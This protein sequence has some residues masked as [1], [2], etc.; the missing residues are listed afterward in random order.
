MKS[1][2]EKAYLRRASQGLLKEPLHSRALRLW[3]GPGEAREGVLQNW[4]IDGYGPFLWI[5]E[6]EAALAS[7]T[8]LAW[9]ERLAQETQA[10]YGPLGFEGAVILS[11]PR[12]GVPEL[13]KLLW[14]AVPDEKF[15]VR[16]GDLRFW[17]RLFGSR[18]PGLF[19]DH[20]PLRDWLALSG[21]CRRKKVLNT[22]S[23]TGSLSVAASLGGAQ[24]VTTL[25]LSKATLQW[26]KE[27]AELNEIS[28]D[29]S[30]WIAGD[31]FEEIPRLKRRGERFGVVISDPPSFSRGKKSNFSTQKDLVRLHQ[32]LL[33]VLEPG[34]IL[35][36]SI[37]SANV[38]WKH[39]EREVHEAARLAG[40]RLREMAPIRQPESFPSSPEMPRSDYLKGIIAECESSGGSGHSKRIV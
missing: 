34:G 37:N 2:L 17:I 35:V 25:D 10:F 21:A 23:Y 39:F 18:H 38:S 26:A 32:N 4:A 16:E 5:T 28:S 27:N 22:F 6:W 29:Q 24:H 15:E 14:G 12:Q 8:D 31:F 40:V 30:R 19:L 20:R 13:P 1:Q 33:S 9:I 7:A 36:S 11:R 3:Y